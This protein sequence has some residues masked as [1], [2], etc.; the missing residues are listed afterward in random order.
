MTLIEAMN[1]GK[2]YR[3]KGEKDWY[4]AVKNY[5]DYVFPVRA[6]LADDWEIQKS[7]VI[8]ADQFFHAYSEALKETEIED[9]LGI[10]Q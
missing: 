8:T 1:S 10:S 4:D 3:R 5:P 2:K 6:I 9:T 7:Q